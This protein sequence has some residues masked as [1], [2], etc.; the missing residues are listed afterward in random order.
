MKKKFLVFALVIFFMSVNFV[1]CGRDAVPEEAPIIEMAVQVDEQDSDEMPMAGYSPVEND[2]NSSNSND[3]DISGDRWT[4][5]G[6]MLRIDGLNFDFEVDVS[7]VINEIS[8]PRREILLD[9]I[10][11]L[12]IRDLEGATEHNMHYDVSVMVTPESSTNESRVLLSG[13]GSIDGRLVTRGADILRFNNSYLI[14][15]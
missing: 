2:N 13:R 10:A 3:I 1:A 15:K 14:N 11:E 9:R 6:Y 12:I 4:L 8:S 5:S 7:E